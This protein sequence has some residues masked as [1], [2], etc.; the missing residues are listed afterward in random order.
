[1]PRDGLPYVGPLNPDSRHAFVITGLRKWGLTNGTAAALMVADL[2]NGIPNHW[3]PLFDSN[4]APS[5]TG[6]RTERAAETT[7][8]GSAGGGESSPGDVER[9]LADLAPGD[10]T[11]IETAGTSTAYY[12]DQA[13]GIQAVSAICTHLGC[14]VGFN[15]GD[16]TWDCPCHGSRFDVDGKVIQ[17][18]ATEDLP[19]RRWPGVA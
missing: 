19:P 18:P 1:M 11:V 4:R 13:G 10:G 3:A 17:G 7:A 16:R 6:G 8:A 2:L 9:Q 14:T 5:R 12:R 15:R